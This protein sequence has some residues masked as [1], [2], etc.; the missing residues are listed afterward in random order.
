MQVYNHLTSALEKKTSRQ[1]EDIVAEWHVTNKG[2]V[3][4]VLTC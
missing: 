4:N 2:A 1:N 3:Q